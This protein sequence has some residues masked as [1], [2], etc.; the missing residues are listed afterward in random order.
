MLTCHS[1]LLLLYH[2]ERM[3]PEYCG[4]LIYNHVYAPYHSKK[5]LLLCFFLSGEWIAHN[6]SDTHVTSQI[7]FSPHFL[8]PIS[9]SRYHL[10]SPLTVCSCPSSTLVTVK[11]LSQHTVSVFPKLNPLY[12]IWHLML[13][14]VIS[15]RGFQIFDLFCC[16]INLQNSQY[17]PLLFFLYLGPSWW[18]SFKF[19]MLFFTAEMSFRSW[20][21]SCYPPH[22][23]T[24]LII[25][26]NWHVVVLFSF[27]LESPC[28]D[29][30]PCTYA[31]YISPCPSVLCP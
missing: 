9:F 20:F 27:F 31:N 3:T 29:I 18:W 28:Y 22:T 15:Y 1:K 4:L 6:S 21:I 7:N 19:L 23:P 14:L 16:D 2:G 11:L 26:F 13:F 30:H 24:P 25:P 12:V 17:F 5:I 10:H 8:Q